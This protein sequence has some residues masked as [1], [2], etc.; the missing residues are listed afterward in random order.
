MFESEKLLLRA[1]EPEDLDLLYAWENN[2]QLWDAG[3]T[4]VPYSRYNLKQ[5]IQ[6]GVQD[7][8]E[9][10]QL[11]L[12]IIEKEQNDI[13]GTV[14]LFDFEPHHSR[15][16]LGLFI[17]PNYRL[18]GFAKE[19][20]HLIEEYVFSFLKINQLYV[21]IATSNTA[22]LRTFQNENYLQT[23]LLKNWIKTSK[24]YEDIIVFQRFNN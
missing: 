24:G 16:A 17:A 9:S 22:S 2:S 12:M 15:I 14:D 8:Y 23:A 20:V 21:Q 5:Y 1:V 18:K 11:R 7:I 4:R 3:N 13:I 6:Q 10:K 19:T